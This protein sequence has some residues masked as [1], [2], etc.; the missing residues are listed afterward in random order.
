MLEETVAV[1]D[2]KTGFRASDT[3]KKKIPFCPRST[4]SN[5]P[6]AKMRSSAER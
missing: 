5:P 4:L 6:H 3:S 2:R 1:D